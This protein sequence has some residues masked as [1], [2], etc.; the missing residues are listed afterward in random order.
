MGN[1]YAGYGARVITPPLGIELSGYGYY[2]DRRAE[3]VQDDLTARAVAIESAGQRVILISCDLIGFTIAFSDA[4]RREIAAALGVP[5]QQILLACTHTHTGPASMSL[6]GIGVSDDCYLAD[7]QQWIVEAA[8][9]AV[10]DLAE[11]SFAYR[12]EMIEPIGYNRRNRSFDPIDPYL[13]VAVLSRADHSI[14][15]LNYACHPVMRSVSSAVSADWPGATCREIERQGHHG[16]V[17]QG[18]CGDINPVVLRQHGRE[19]NDPTLVGE[20]LCRRAFKAEQY[21]I[22]PETLS[23]QAVER[24]IRL[25][26][27]ILSPGEIAEEK[28]RCLEQEYSAGFERFLNAWEI[29]ANARAVELR[30][31]PY[32]QH[33]PLQAIALGNMYLLGIPG[34][35][36]CQYGLRLRDSYPNLFTCGYANGNISYLPTPD[37]YDNLSD[38]AAYAAAKIYTVFPFT[39]QVKEIVL[40]ESE[41]VLQQV[42][43]LQTES[44]LSV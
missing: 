17:F 10:D 14:Y 18:F 9:A 27:A 34:E 20:L 32:L 28:Q 21:A 36:F 41:Q 1:C 26:L 11:A 23:I 19:N 12:S 2:L 37:A 13:N 24:R 3:S 5:A 31:A 39:P 42:V 25:P 43:H 8:Q 35:V 29:L 44:P 15:L 7:L 22:V 4:I 40:G 6:E 33:V 16:I 38:Y 30:D